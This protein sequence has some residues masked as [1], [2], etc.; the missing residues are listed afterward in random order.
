MSRPRMAWHYHADAIGGTYA[1]AKQFAPDRL[2]EHT[3]ALKRQADAAVQELAR[4]ETAYTRTAEGLAAYASVT[5]YLRETRTGLSASADRG[6][7]VVEQDGTTLHCAPTIHALADWCRTQDIET[8][9][10]P[11]GGFVDRMAREWIT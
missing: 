8:T 1:H 4:M 10:A 6:F 7:C 5:H 3:H 11:T 2:W 9:K